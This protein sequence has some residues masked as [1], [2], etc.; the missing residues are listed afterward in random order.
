MFIVAIGK[1]V[2]YIYIYIIYS[3]NFPQLYTYI[4]IYIYI[5]REK[6]QINYKF[7]PTGLFRGFPLIR[8]NPLMSGQPR[9]RPVGMNL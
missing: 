2:F 9:N 3:S 4:N 6:R 1:D 5:V 8:E 7:I